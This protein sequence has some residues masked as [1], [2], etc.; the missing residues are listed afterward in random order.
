MGLMGKL[1]CQTSIKTDGDVFH[2][3]FR[4]R[5]HHL[6]TMTPENI[7]GCDLHEGEFGKVGSVVIWKY[8]IDGKHMVAK[9]RVEAIDEEEKQVTFNV[10]EGDLLKD[11]KIFVISVH[12]DTSGID[13]LVTWSFDYEKVDESVKDPT[14]YLDFVLRLTKDIDTHHLP[15]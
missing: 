14:P 6:H 3:I 15:K 7:Q 11:F 13:S 10:V 8:F 1:I 2:D 9:E 4:T 5:P 12:V